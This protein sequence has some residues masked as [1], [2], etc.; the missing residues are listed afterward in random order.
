MPPEHT[1]PADSPDRAPDDAPAGDVP[2]RVLDAAAYL[3]GL[4]AAGGAGDTLSTGFP[5]LDAL[6]GGGLRRGD[7]VVLGGDVGCGKSALALAMALRAAEAGRSVALFS[8]ELSGERLLERALAVEGRAALDDLRNGRLGEEAYAA[9]AAAA[10]AMRQH[11]ALLSHMPPNGLPGMSDLLIEHLGLD[12]L[13]VDPLQSLAR[14]AL[15][16]EEELAQVVRDL[17]GMAV[18]RDCAVLL[19]SHLAVPVRERGDPRP[20]LDDFGALGALRQLADT[21]LGLYREELYETSRDVEGAA[22]A[23]VLKQRNG[24]VGYADLYF[25]KRWLRFEDMVEPDR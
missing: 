14:G 8:G 13:V 9:V 15:P 19:V 11:P 2:A 3:E 22:E 16:M 23:H 20:R 5:S 25:Y 21:V 17:K 1:L 24:G 10:L 6:L 12:L 18:R 7:L 4:A